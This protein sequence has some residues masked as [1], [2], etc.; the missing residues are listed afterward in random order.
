MAK[1][2]FESND[3]PLMLGVT[4]EISSDREAKFEA[5]GYLEDLLRDVSGYF[6]EHNS[7]SINVTNLDQGTQFSLVLNWIDAS[8]STLRVVS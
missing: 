5:V 7:I 4:Q 3:G 8:R 6:W 2:Y 1:Y